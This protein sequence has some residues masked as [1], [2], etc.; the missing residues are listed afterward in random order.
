MKIE[1]IG[2]RPGEKLYEELIIEGE[3]IVPTSHDKI[4]VLKGADPNPEDFDDNVRDLLGMAK[5]QDGEKLVRKL[6]EIV[7][8]Y[9]PQGWS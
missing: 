6:Q 7:H 8:E 9:K 1:I 5:A 3:G 4:M 2:L